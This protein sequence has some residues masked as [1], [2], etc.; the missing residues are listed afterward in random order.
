M[1]RLARLI[2]VEVLE[3]LRSD[4]HGLIRTLPEVSEAVQQARGRVIS[5]GWIARRRDPKLTSCKVSYGVDRFNRPGAQFN[6]TNVAR[7]LP[8][9]DFARP[10]RSA[11][12][13]QSPLS[14]ERKAFLLRSDPLWGIDRVRLKLHDRSKKFSAKYVAFVVRSMH[15]GGVIHSLR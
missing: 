3:L 4:A 13:L 15:P 1:L 14:L 2:F 7:V 9:D 11:A 12:Q 6:G 10:C 8:A 5:L